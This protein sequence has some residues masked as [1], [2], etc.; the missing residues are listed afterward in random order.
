MN[1]IDGMPHRA[2]EVISFVRCTAN[3]TACQRQAADTHV[4]LRL[5]RQCVTLSVA[6]SSFG[7]STAREHEASAVI[8][9]AAMYRDVSVSLRN[10]P[11]ADELELYLGYAR[12]Q[13]ERRL[14]ET[15]DDAVRYASSK[16]GMRALPAS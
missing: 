3:R 16:S 14:S 12:C 7:V 6:P 9:N 5:F 4:E 1:S 10:L 8:A 15:E 13:V 2:R 11:T